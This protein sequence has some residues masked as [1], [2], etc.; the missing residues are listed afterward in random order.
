M[1]SLFLQV[2][3]EKETE[4][5]PETLQALI[6]KDDCKSLDEELQKLGQKSPKKDQP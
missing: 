1:E 3:G 4:G 2:L 5:N 6:D